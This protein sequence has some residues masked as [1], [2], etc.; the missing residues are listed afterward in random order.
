MGIVVFLRFT[1]RF[2]SR[3]EIASLTLGAV[4]ESRESHFLRW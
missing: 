3:F 4:A 2:I 1:N